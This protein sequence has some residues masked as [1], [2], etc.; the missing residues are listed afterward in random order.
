MINFVFFQVKIE[1]D[2]YAQYRNRPSV[3]EIREFYGNIEY[4]LLYEFDKK[5][6]MLA[7]ICWTQETNEDIVGVRS[8]IGFG[9]YEFIDASAID[10][11]VGF[12]KINDIYH[13]VDKEVE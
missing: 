8:F 5:M 13:I 7:K 2:I 11:C 1:V 3:F 9:A 6:T 10:H 4:Y 12:L